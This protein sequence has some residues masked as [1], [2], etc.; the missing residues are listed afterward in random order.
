MAIV[1]NP[2]LRLNKMGPHVKVVDYGMGNVGSVISALKY[3]GAIAELVSDP[4][5]IAKA[6][7]LI[8]PGVGSFK[9]G[10][11]NLK[12]NGIDEIIRSA[13]IINKTNI[14]GICLGMQLLGSESTENCKTEGLGLITNRVERFSNQELGK[15][16]IPHIGFNSIHFTGQ[17]GLFKD[18]LEP[19]DFYFAHS[20]RMLVDNID[21]PYATCSYG[22]DFLAA[23][24]MDN[25]CG[26]QFHPEKSQ[27]NGLIFLR[28]FLN[29]DRKC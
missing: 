24:E 1:G 23:F 21:E 5:V 17:R 18:L 11:E 19:S 7:Y 3:L 20:Y 22:I 27:A 6:D 25:I 15:N 16:K 14:L 10:M 28:N 2:S 4:K 12:K 29:K 8:L 26:A 9:K 13:A